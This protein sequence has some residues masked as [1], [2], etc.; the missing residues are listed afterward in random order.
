VYGIASLE[1][2]M[3]DL[4]AVMDAVGSQRAA[5]LGVSEGGPM[6]LLF[7][8]SHPGRTAALV[9]MGS[10]ARR[11]WAEDYPVGARPEHEGWLRPTPQQWGREAAQRFL[12]ERAPSI[13]GD[14]EAIR[15]YASYLV[16]GA[17]PNA[18]AQ[19]TDMNEEID[20]RH[21]LPSVRVPAL[22]LY[23]AEEYMR[24]A[25]RYLGARL[26]RAQVAELPGADHLPWE[27][28]QADVL[29]EIERF[30]TGLQ[31]EP[32][33]EVILT[34]IL[35]LE[36]VEDGGVALA[37]FR[38]KRQDERRSSFDGPARA[39]QCALALRQTHPELRAGVH[40]GEC[41]RHDGRLSG[42]ALEIAAGVASEAK[43]G[44]ILVTSTVHDLVALS[45]LELEPHGTRTLPL[46]GASR[47]WRLFRA[48]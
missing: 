41:E 48:L 15:W 6:S 43:P 9:T 33:P 10:Y 21:V 47:E 34:T 1:E 27:G 12:S 39:V 29:A 13:A 46:A 8:A 28:A 30:L 22:V 40:T 14:E 16:R 31:V 7:A 2:R 19:V 45:G 3:D 20:V 18:V 32:E 24:D 36:G 17:S 25:S 35:D 26:P 4:R 23:R 38:G 44:E 11:S 5:L 37:R 42:A